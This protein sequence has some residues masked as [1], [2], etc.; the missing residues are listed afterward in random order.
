[1]PHEKSGLA[2]TVTLLAAS[3]NPAHAQTEWT[4]RFNNDWLLS[5]NWTAGFPRQT[6]DGIINTVT[7]HSTVIESAGAAARSLDIGQGGSGMLVIRSGGTLAVSGGSA[8]GNLPRGVGTVEVIG[9]GA[10]WSSAS[11]VVVGGLG[12]GTLLI[13]DGGTVNSGGG[14]VGLSVGPTGP[15]AGTVTVTGAGSNWS[16]SGTIVVGGQGTGTLVIQGAGLL[17]SGGGSVGLSG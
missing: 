10:N 13:Q 17:E 12:T 6:T 1:M 2:L 5:G 11:S 9:A 16:N 15:G 7:P 14:S 4:G 3:I 8:I